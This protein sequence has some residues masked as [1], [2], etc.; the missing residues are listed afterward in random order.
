MINEG[1]AF[2]E[3]E[4]KRT[5]KAALR[6]LSDSL[7]DEIRRELSHVI[8]TAMTA[9]VERL[10]RLGHHLRPYDAD[11]LGLAF[12]DDA[13]EESGYDCK[14]RVACDFTISTGYRDVLYS[15]SNPEGFYPEDVRIPRDKNDK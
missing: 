5:D 13:E 4:N 8:V 9:I 1:Y 15:K 12:R 6:A 3:F 2:S 7:A 14:L 10:N 11:E